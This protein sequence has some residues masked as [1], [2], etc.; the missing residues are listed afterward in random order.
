[1]DNYDLL[2][3]A[4]WFV[5]SLFFIILSYYFKAKATIQENATKAVDEAENLDLPGSEK[6]KVAVDQVMGCVPP[7]LK[8]IISRPFIEVVI[9]NTFDAIDSYAKK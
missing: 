5:G 7:L 9:Q 3:D 1:M 6:F 8:P 4:I 2:I